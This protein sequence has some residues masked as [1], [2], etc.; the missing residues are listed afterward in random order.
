M[1]IQTP[2]KYLRFTTLSSRAINQE[3]W[4]AVSSTRLYWGLYLRRMS[5]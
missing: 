1:I 5:I 4:P 3:V 2:S